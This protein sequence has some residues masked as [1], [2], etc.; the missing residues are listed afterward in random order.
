[1]Q[2]HKTRRGK[3]H[4]SIYTSM[5]WGFEKRE[6]ERE[7]KKMQKGNVRNYRTTVTEVRVG[8][9]VGAEIEGKFL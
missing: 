1:M 5:I 4:M 2:I 6:R 8:T 3:K 9:A 7:D